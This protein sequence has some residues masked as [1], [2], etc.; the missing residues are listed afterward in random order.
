MAMSFQTLG[1]ALRELKLSDA[2]LTFEEEHSNVLGKGLPLWL[3]RHA[4]LGN[5]Y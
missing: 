2:S 3:S 4:P 1:R 5:Y